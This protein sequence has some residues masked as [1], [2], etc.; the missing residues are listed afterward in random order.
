[1]ENLPVHK[2]FIINFRGVFV[3]FYF[4]FKKML[5]IPGEFWLIKLK[6]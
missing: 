6:N 1:M 3:C 4:L 2:I 5:L